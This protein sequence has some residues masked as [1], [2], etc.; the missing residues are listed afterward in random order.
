MNRQVFQTFC[1]LA[2]IDL[3]LAQNGQEGIERYKSHRF[4]AMV[5]DCYMPKMNGYEFVQ[6]IR[7]WEN[8][9][10]SGHMPIFALTADASTRNREKCFE[11]GFDEFLTKPYTRATLRFIID[12]IG[13]INSRS[14]RS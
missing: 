14:H 1:K 3:I 9:D 6:L 11:A 7:Q 12:R 8:E 4:D 10:D 5:V 13:R 2:S